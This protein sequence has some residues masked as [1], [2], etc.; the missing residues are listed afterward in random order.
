MELWDAKLTC[1]MVLLSFLNILLKAELMLYVVLH[2]PCARPMFSLLRV[3]WAKSIALRFLLVALFLA[4][5]VRSSSAVVMLSSRTG[6]HFCAAI[7]ASIGHV[8]AVLFCVVGGVL[9]GQT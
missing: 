8:V 6:C 3:P 7:E 2:P 9:L 1:R 5:S 4:K